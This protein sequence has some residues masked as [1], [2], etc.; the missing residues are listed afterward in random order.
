M[1]LNAH[2]TEGEAKEERVRNLPK[3]TVLVSD[4]NVIQTLTGQ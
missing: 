2:L 3:I 4:G 1:K